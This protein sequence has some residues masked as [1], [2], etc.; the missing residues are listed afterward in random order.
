M[1]EIRKINTPNCIVT[2]LDNAPCGYEEM[3]SLAFRFDDAKF[4][5]LIKLPKLKYLD[6]VQVNNDLLIQLNYDPLR[7][8]FNSFIDGFESR[9][10]LDDRGDAIAYLINKSIK[11][12]IK[13][14]E[15][16]LEL[17]LVACMGLYGELL[18][19][20]EL[21]TEKSDHSYILSGWGCR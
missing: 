10:N 7:E 3:K 17:S 2:I 19:L 21:L 5:Q 15:K 6:I 9:V 11:D 20:K 13:I 16:E 4:L 12:L 18:Q 1:K 14:A 8:F